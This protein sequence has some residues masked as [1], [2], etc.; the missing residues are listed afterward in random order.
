MT[1]VGSQHLGFSLNT[2]STLPHMGT[3]RAIGRWCVGTG[4][5]LYSD[6]VVC[7]TISG[8]KV[9]TGWVDGAVRVFDVNLKSIAM[10]QDL[11]I[12]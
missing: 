4:R 10:M 3:W 7:L 1:T 5:A 2:K 6:E 11:F 12:C 9:A 8:D